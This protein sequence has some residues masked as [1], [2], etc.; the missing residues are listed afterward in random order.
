MN[1]KETLIITSDLYDIQEITDLLLAEYNNEYQEVLIESNRKGVT[2]IVE[3]DDFLIVSAE[4]AQLLFTYDI[5]HFT[6]AK[7][8]INEE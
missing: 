1:E 5:D 4:V 8:Y 2:M 7:G 3:E 6:L